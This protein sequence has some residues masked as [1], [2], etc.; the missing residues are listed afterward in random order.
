MGKGT[1]MFLE[2]DLWMKHV[3]L[4]LVLKEVSFPSVVLTVNLIYLL[5]ISEELCTACQGGNDDTFWGTIISLY[6]G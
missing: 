2:Q 5:Q 6:N 4:P 1:D 3:L